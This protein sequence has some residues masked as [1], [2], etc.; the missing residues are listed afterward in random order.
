MTTHGW[1]LLGVVALPVA[2]AAQT[3]ARPAAQRPRPLPLTQLDDRVVAAD[4][5]NRAFTLTFAQPLPIKDLLLLLVRGTNLSMI[6]DPRISGSFIGELKNVTVRQALGLVLPPLGL[7]FAADGGVV[8]VFVREPETRLFDINYIATLRTGSSRVG[9]DIAGG[10][11]SF[12]Q[13]TGTT[14]TDLFKELTKGMQTLL[15]DRAVFNVDRKAGLAQVTDFPERLDRVATY[16]EAVQDRVH[17]QVQIDARIVEVELNDADAQGLDWTALT[18]AATGDASAGRPGHSSTGL[19]VSDVGKFMSAL[20]SQGRVSTLAHPRL[21][22]INNEPAIVRSAEGARREANS[23]DV[24]D[25][26]AGLDAVTLSVT[27][28]IGAD[29]VVMLSLSPIV[30]LRSG[31]AGAAGA[32]VVRESDTLARVADGETIV[33]S[34]FGRDRERRERKSVGRTGGWF[35]R[36]T[37]VTKKRVEL[38]VLLTPKILYSTD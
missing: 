9:N 14:S 21:L 37:V 11:G 2:L 15:S 23:S 18:R 31:Q 38:L 6:P 3:P 30:V 26:A 25:G 19:L 35:G 1:I 34:G 20:A 7:D 24:G 10:A 4:L 8:R 36:A 32:P 33:L 16:L 29:G 27:P 12:A 13:V 17:R 22:A 5:D 28:Q